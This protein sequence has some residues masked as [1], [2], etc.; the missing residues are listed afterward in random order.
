MTMGARRLPHTY[1]MSVV[2]A[3]AEAEAEAAIQRARSLFASQP[4]PPAAAANA[5]GAVQNA[6]QTTTTA[7]QATS[8][9]SGAFHHT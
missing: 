7:G 6:A 3:C 8:D 5:A 4:E 1:R 9:M 2:Q